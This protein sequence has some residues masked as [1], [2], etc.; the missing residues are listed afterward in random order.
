MEIYIKYEGSFDDLA[1]IIRCQLNIASQNVSEYIHEQKR[2]SMNYGGVYY[3]FEAI[4]CTF[5][6]LNN[7]GEVE[8]P[9][10]SDFMYYLIVRCEVMPKHD[11]GIFF[12][13]ECIEALLAKKGLVVVVDNLS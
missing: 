9:E 4:G 1:E 3:I 10:R 13:C 6:L 12:I 2:E 5:T 11:K 8:I 7:S